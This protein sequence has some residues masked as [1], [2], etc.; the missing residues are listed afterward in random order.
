MKSSEQITAEIAQEKDQLDKLSRDL[1]NYHSM[2]L[3][4]EIEDREYFARWKTDKEWAI[5]RK[6]QKIHILTWVL[7]R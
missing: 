5:S 6:E 1:R 4:G 7:G 2:E 3:A